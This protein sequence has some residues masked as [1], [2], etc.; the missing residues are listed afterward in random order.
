MNEREDELLKDIDEQFNEIY[1]DERIIK[2][3]E[4][5]LPN[6]IKAS[7]EKGKIIDKE[8]DNN[9]AGLNSLINDCIIIENYINN[10]ILI[11]QSIQ[12]NNN[13]TDVDIGFTPGENG[14]NLFIE[15]INTFGKISVIQNKFSFIKFPIVNNSQYT[16]TGDKKYI[17][18]KMN[19]RWIGIL[20]E[21]ELIKYKEY[22]WKI[23]IIK[24]AANHIRVGVVPKDF[25]IKSTD[26]Y[27]CG[28]CFYNYYGS[29]YSRPPHNYN[30]K[31]TNLKIAKNE[32]LIVMNMSKGTMK[33]IIDN[34]DKGES[35]SNIPL[36]K[37]LVPVIF[38]YDSG[39]CVEVSEC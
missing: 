26:N 29:L 38:L 1:Y 15:T 37:P 14:I 22:K 18:T 12:K 36:D 23:K 39:I 27:C 5:L 8:W 13:N 6:K 19:E 7:L 10:I 24:N 3:S 2:E 9:D 30:N 33:F 21:K 16:I 28:W 32:I 31:K 4:K 17:L 25:D 20:C 11:N 34:E 35:F